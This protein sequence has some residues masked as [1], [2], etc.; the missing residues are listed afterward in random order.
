V[1][2]L[3]YDEWEPFYLQI[4]SEF[5]FSRRDDE[6]C[7]RRLALR[8]ARPPFAPAKVWDAL[9]Q[10]IRGRPVNVLG[11][12]DDAAKGLKR[13]R[14]RLPLLAADGATTAALEAGIVPTGIVS[15]LDGAMEDEIEATRRGAKILV[16]AH[17]DNGPAISRWLP[18]LEPTRVAGTCQ[19]RPVAPLRNLGG[20]TD[21]DR[22]CFVAHALGAT[23]IRLVGFD[24]GA[25]PGRYT[26][27]FDPKTKPRKM[28]WAQKLLDELATRGAVIG[29]S[30]TSRPRA[31]GG[32]QRAR[33]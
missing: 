27:A 16:H 22:A 19:S 15:D 31:I 8:L 12:A 20:F 21:G 1:I 32:T 9:D 17:G 29:P 14:S 33:P 4:V 24:L 13:L 30:W 2:G 10:E 5:G 23:R 6:D 11:A 28:W 25:D 7:A 26:G 3:E 18:R